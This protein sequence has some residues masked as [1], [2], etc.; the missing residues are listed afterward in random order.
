MKKREFTDHGRLHRYLT[1]IAPGLKPASW[2]LIH[3]VFEL[4]SYRKDEVILRRGETCGY[5]WFI[6]SG[7]V[8][9]YDVANGKEKVNDLVVED[10]FFSELNSFLFQLPS[11]L[12]IRALE[13]TGT[14]R[15]SYRDVQWLYETVA[16]ADRI[17]RLI[18]EKILVSQSERIEQLMLLSPA[19]RYRH[20]LDRRPEL[21]LRVP[22]YL[23]ASYLSMSPESLSR[24]RSK[25]NKGR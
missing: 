17:G 3:D 20:F 16:E 10:H 2:R 24:I 21:L 12:G 23:I 11:R 7:I 6:N 9:K 14:L 18:A 5:V 15:I 8:E 25:L 13:D 1:R 4:R 22:Q 19:E